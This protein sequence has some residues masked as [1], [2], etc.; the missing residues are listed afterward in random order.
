MGVLNA[1]LITIA[2]IAVLWLGVMWL[3]GLAAAHMNLVAVLSGIALPLTAV[4]M[5]AMSIVADP[6]WWLVLVAAVP[7]LLGLVAAAIPDEQGWTYYRAHIFTRGRRGSTGGV[8]GA[9]RE[10]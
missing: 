7:L 8:A 2:S 4:I 5:I 1:A 9:R 3:L 10:R 6:G